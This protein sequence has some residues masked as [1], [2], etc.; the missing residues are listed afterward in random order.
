MD[1]VERCLERIIEA[2]LRIG[3]ERM[4]RIAPEMPLHKMRGLANRLRH[5]YDAVD[6]RYVWDT[7]V[8]ELP[9]LRRACQAALTAP[10]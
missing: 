3:S 9:A 4:Q 1:A 10:R 7:V 2:S 6:R 8:D 5:E